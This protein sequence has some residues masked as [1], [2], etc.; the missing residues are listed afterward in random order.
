MQDDDVR[1]VA[2]LARL[3]VA[4]DRLPAL[5]R[6]L[7]GILA[8]MEQLSAVEIPV[9]GE[10]GASPAAMPLRPDDGVQIPMER[11]RESFAPVMRDGFFVVPRLES[12]DDGGSAA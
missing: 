9:T 11:A 1:A 7:N 3:G 2:A 5:A 10:T 8:H 12:H 4:P 6:E